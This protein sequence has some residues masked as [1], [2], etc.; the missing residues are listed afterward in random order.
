MR[1][2]HISPDEV[3]DFI[4]CYI[5]VFE[6]LK[7]ILPLDYVDGQI[8]K[9]T[10][11]DFYDRLISEFDSPDNILLAASL[12]DKL[13]GMTWGGIKDDGS[14]WLG[15]MG[16]K[17]PYRRNGT[18]RALL[19]RFIDICREKGVSKVRLNTDEALV[20]A[21]SLYESEGFV[22]DGFIKN[23]YGL[24]LILFTKIL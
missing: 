8:E 21:I 12:D 15:F 17:K 2:Y 4:D 3:Q 14:A 16:V 5:E 19:H 22:R 13:I 20:Q 11:T 1:I 7:G 10:K 9:A 23:Q 24:E 18:G 6:T